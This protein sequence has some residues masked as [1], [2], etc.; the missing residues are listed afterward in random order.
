MSAPP[1]QADAAAP[2]T[3]A[4]ATSNDP[5][6]AEKSDCDTSNRLVVDTNA[7]LARM[8]FGD[9]AF[10]SAAD[11]V[12][13]V[14]SMSVALYE[15]LF[16]FRLR[17]VERVP[18]TLQDY[19]H[20]AQLVADAL[21]SAL[22]E[23]SSDADVGAE[24]LTG[25]RLCAGDLGSIR[26]LLNMLEQVYALLFEESQEVGDRLRDVSLASL[27]METTEGLTTSK[28]RVPPKFA[29]K[30]RKES[31]DSAPKSDDPERTSL[32]EKR[33]SKE[34]RTARRSASQSRAGMKLEEVRVGRAVDELRGRRTSS[35]SGTNR[36]RLDVST[37]RADAIAE[38]NKKRSRLLEQSFNAS[39]TSRAEV[40]AKEAA[41]KK[42]APRALAKKQKETEQEL[43]KTKKYGRF[44]TAADSASSDEDKPREDGSKEEPA[45][46]FFEGVS[47]VQHNSDESMHFME[48]EGAFAQNFS[49]ISIE[50]VEPETKEGELRAGHD[51]ADQ[52]NAQPNENVDVKKSAP[53]HKSTNQQEAEE[54][55]GTTSSPVKKKV[56]RDEPH[57]PERPSLR[58]TR[59]DQ[60]KSLY[61]L[62]PKTKHAASASKAQAQYLR[63][64]LSLK[65]HLQEL[66]QREASQRQHLERAYKSGEHMANVDKIRSRRF[67]QDVRLHRIAIGL[68]AKNEEEKQLR[69]AMNHL[70]GLEKEKL[71]E[72][73][74]VT[75]TVLKQIQ[76]EHVEREQAMENFYANQIQ[77]VK[78]Q[79]R[80][81]A[82]ERELVEKA[83]RSA[84]EKM[85][86]ELRHERENQLAALLQEKQHLEE[87]RK[88]RHASQMTQLLEK[89]DERSARRTDAFYTAAMKA[90]ERHIITKQQAL[91]RTSLDPY[92]TGTKPL[93]RSTRLSTSTIR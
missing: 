70:L 67:E 90:R 9:R 41:T 68:E 92:Q 31:V 91:R 40:A 25:R 55:D 84:S 11:L 33:R 32:R 87:T 4:I 14:S 24:E 64:K 53:Q 54:E 52:E 16:Q 30:Q 42:A 7:L 79:T 15:K 46:V 19:E 1:P 56:A 48:E 29:K 72:E 83:Q 85:M 10:A 51:I 47:S 17:D 76:K 34:T 86:R 5:A 88:F 80:R 26:R 59:R 50:D 39:S 22:L 35:L 60:S 71:R 8:G 36:S 49:S 66:R 62:V 28:R 74:R 61:P 57:A 78:E 93:K 2:P 89:T 18:R 75:T 6:P 3:T 37:K 65:N 44:V 12:A 21:R 82:K 58:K 20:N 43:L 45:V 69:H 23:Q 77:L 81:E 63:Y 13:S 73:H 27:G 38:N